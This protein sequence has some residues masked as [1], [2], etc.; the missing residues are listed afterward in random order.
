MSNLKTKLKLPKYLLDTS[1]F[2]NDNLHNLFDLASKIKNTDRNLL[3]DTLRGKCIGLLFMEPSSRTYLSFSSAIA[4]LGGTSINLQLDKSSIIKGESMED[5]FLTFQTYVD[6]IIIRTS[7]PNFFD[8]IKTTNLINIP[9]INAGLGN[10][11]HP[12]QGLLDLFTINEEKGRINGLEIS[13]V[14]DLKNGRTVKS[15]LNLLKNFSVK[16]NLVPY[17]D[18]LYLDNDFLN[19][20]KN[21]N[22]T[23]KRKNTLQSIIKDSDIIYMTRIQQERG[24]S[25]NVFTINKNILSQSKDDIRI[26][27]P[28]PRNMEISKDIDLDPKAAYFRQ[29]KNGLWIRMAIIYNILNNY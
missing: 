24:S 18:D 17:N 16:I 28:F 15:L 13:I 9:I 1:F 23:I 25:G 29:M 6:A 14:G 21:Q 7:D 22:I 27:H 11:S 19:K 3:K 12:T 2:T 5:T 8:I 20:I 10:I 4:L 26:M